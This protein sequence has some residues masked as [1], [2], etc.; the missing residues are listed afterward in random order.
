MLEN[1]IVDYVMRFDILPEKIQEDRIYVSRGNRRLCKELGIKLSGKPL[2]KPSKD[3]PANLDKSDVGV[4]VE[5]EGKFGT[6]KTR[7]GWSRIMARMLETGEAV[8]SMAVLAMNLNKKVK[9]F[10]RVFVMIYNV[11]YYSIL[12][13]A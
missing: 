4:R 13:V 6:L 10:L 5:I 12:D 8:I 9:S 2:G 11:P 3:S 1:A 7:N